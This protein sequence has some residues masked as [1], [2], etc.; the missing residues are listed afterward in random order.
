MYFDDFC[1]KEVICA[2]DCCKLGNVYNIEFDSCSGCICQIF[3]REKCGL[4]GFFGVGEELMI[5]FQNIKQ[6][7]PDIILVEV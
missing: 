2:K 1:K 7:G 3:V 4:K 5:P 6:I